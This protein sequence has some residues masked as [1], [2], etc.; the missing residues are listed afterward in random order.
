MTN[1]IVMAACTMALR[2]AG[3]GIAHH[4]SKTEKARRALSNASMCL[5]V[6]FLVM[7]IHESQ[8]LIWATIVTIGVS[9]S[10]GG[11]QLPLLAGIFFVL[12]S[13]NWF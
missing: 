6:V 8:D 1:I 11:M 5:M 13:R 12:V 10:W 3:F 7:Q 4:F 9:L 2:F